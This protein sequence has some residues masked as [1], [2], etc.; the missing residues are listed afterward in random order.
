[1]ITKIIKIGEKDYLFGASGDTPRRYRLMFH[2]DVFSQFEKLS[3]GNL[4][5][6]VIEQLAF[7]MYKQANPTSE[8]ADIG[9]WLDTFEPM[10]LYKIAPQLFDLWMNN[11]KSTS[12]SK[13]K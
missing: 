11:N 4:D 5:M 3:N 7:V 6:T 8:F 12:K 1:M 2:A 13:K 10:D 9:D